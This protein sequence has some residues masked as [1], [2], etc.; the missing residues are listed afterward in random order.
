MLILVLLLVNSVTVMFH[1]GCSLT[2]LCFIVFL[3]L[4]LRINI[5]MYCRAARVSNKLTYLLIYLLIY[6][7]LF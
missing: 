7:M 5:L 6:L 1:V 4:Y 2:H 3:S